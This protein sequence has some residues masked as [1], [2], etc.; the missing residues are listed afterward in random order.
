MAITA[1]ALAK[2]LGIKFNKH[3]SSIGKNSSIRFGKQTNIAQSKNES[4]AI[5]NMA[6]SQKLSLKP[7]LILHLRLGFKPKSNRA[8]V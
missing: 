6:V 1:D 3:F 2:S 5:F 7:S 8:L 4:A